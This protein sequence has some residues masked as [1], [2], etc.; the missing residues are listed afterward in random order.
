MNSAFSASLIA[1]YFLILSATINLALSSS[2]SLAFVNNDI[3]RD[4]SF[5][6]TYPNTDLYIDH[7]KGMNYFS[8]PAAASISSHNAPPNI[9]TAPALTV[10]PVPV[11]VLMQYNTLPIALA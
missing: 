8:L 10:Q 2:F 1:S 11:F 5:A 6:V 4:S 7:I 3:K 9:V